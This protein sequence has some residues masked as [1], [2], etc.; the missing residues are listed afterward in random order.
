VGFDDVP[1]GDLLEPPLTVVRQPTYR[2]G[3][4]AASLLIRRLREP[5]AAIREVVLTASLVL[6]GS[7]G[8]VS[9]AV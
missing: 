7:T 8:P 9:V 2:V 1:T 6:R 3:A 5:D 4:K